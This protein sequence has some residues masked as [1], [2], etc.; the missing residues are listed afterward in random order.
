M[1]PFFHFADDGHA[2]EALADAGFETHESARL[3][4]V[5][6]LAAADD[7]YDMFASGTARTRA[8][9]ERQTDGQRAAIRAALAAGVEGHAAAGGYAVPMPAVRVSAQ[10]PTN[11]DAAA[12]RARR[13]QG[14]PEAANN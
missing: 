13:F 10:R 12:A 9:L 5:A 11:R 4:L 1:L 14:N 3:P 7:L 8:I 6:R 2:A